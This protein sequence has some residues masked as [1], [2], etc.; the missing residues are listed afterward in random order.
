MKKILLLAIASTLL[1]AIVLL[2]SCNK[3]DEPKDPLVGKYIISSAVL[4]E[5]LTLGDTVLASETDLTIAINA[6]LL[7]DAGCNDM[8][9]TRLE[10]KDGGE[11]WYVCVGEG[12]GFSNGTWEINADRTVLSL[13]LNITQGSASVTI[14]LNI[15]ELD[16]GII[17]VSGN[18]QIPLPPE[19]FLVLGIDVTGS[20][21]PIYQTK[22][23]IEITRIP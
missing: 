1:S 9:N 14:P 8:A 7:S 21:V 17:K 4:S 6:A 5:P 10:L 2:P 13:A 22:I 12:T 23:H 15:T 16:E 3:E 11:I 20:G 18:V 19:F